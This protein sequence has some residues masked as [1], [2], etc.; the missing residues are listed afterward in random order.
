M[1]FLYVKMLLRSLQL[2]HFE[3]SIMIALKSYYKHFQYNVNAFMQNA[4]W[5][6]LLYLYASIMHNMYL[7]QYVC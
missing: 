2:S 4:H 7:S 6:W 5:K 1:F 3:W